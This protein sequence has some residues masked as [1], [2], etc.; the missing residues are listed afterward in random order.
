MKPLSKIFLSVLIIG[1]SFGQEPLP[2]QKDYVVSKSTALS[3]SAEVVTIQQPSSG[4]RNVRGRMCTVYSSSAACG[5][6]VE[7]NG[8]AATT[9]E[10]TVSAV[11]PSIAAVPAAFKAYS[12]SNV[13]V[14]IVIGRHEVQAGQTF[15]IDLSYFEMRASGADTSQNL[16]IRTASCT[17]T[18]II[19]CMLYEY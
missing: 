10:M 3:G 13:G 12:A 6:T 15:P 11:R 1:V 8:T 19:N 2:L 18:V 9:T 5:F 7:R 14:G 17:T 16:T 4:A